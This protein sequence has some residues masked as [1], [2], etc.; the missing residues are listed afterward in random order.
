M[1][2][3]G[4]ENDRDVF[5]VQPLRNVAKTAPYSHEASVTELEDA[6]EVMAK[7]QLRR[8]LSEGAVG[9]IVRF[10]EGLSGPLPPHYGPARQD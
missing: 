7:V 5:R 4:N 8:T 10:F 9:E 1:K 2:K 3:T 6:V